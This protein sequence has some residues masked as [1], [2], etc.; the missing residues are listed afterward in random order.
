MAILPSRWAERFRFEGR[1][2]RSLLNRAISNIRALVA[3]APPCFSA[4]AILLAH[5]AWPT[6]ARTGSVAPCPL[7]DRGQDA[8]GHIVRCPIWKG[9]PTFHDIAEARVRSNLNALNGTPQEI[10]Q[11]AIRIYSVYTLANFIREC[12][13]NGDRQGFDIGN[14]QQQLLSLAPKL[15]TSAP[16]T[17]RRSF[18]AWTLDWV[19]SLASPLGL[20]AFYA[21]VSP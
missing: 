19:H 6:A 14:R 9:L 15:A 1:L 21:L 11:R 18:T 12:R 8:H 5:A 3:K 4:A 7:C 13:R 2:A 17:S 16:R 20:F 10:S